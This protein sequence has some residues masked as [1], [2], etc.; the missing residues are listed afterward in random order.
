MTSKNVPNMKFSQIKKLSLEAMNIFNDEDLNE[1]Y[2]TI[3]EYY[4]DNEI[5]IQ[6]DKTTFKSYDRYEKIKVIQYLLDENIPG[7]FS[8]VVRSIWRIFV[9]EI[10]NLP[11]NIYNIRPIFKN[12]IWSYFR[13]KTADEVRMD[14]K[15]KYGTKQ[16]AWLKLFALAFQLMFASKYFSTLVLLPTG[17]TLVMFI[18]TFVL[19]LIANPFTLILITSS[20]SRKRSLVEEV[21]RIYQK[22]WERLQKEEG[23]KKVNEEEEEEEVKVPFLRKNKSRRRQRNV[24]EP[25][26]KMNTKIYPPSRT[27]KMMYRNNGYLKQRL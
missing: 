17:S 18:A 11:S 27:M 14:I 15:S 1:L 7:W 21:K 19:T 10:I 5:G 22:A 6:L 23:L 4:E 20:I 26:L 12:Y 25:S 24:S 16:L 3:K 9:F 13:S 8:T 2:D